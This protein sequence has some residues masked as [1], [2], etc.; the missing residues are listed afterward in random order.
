MNEW[1]SINDF[2]G[3]FSNIDMLHCDTRDFH[4]IF[5]PFGEYEEDTKH[6]I[7]KLRSKGPKKF[8]EQFIIPQDRITEYLKYLLDNTGG[9]ADWRYLFDNKDKHQIWIKYIR[10]YR[11]ND[12]E[13]VCTQG[14]DFDGL[15]WRHLKDN[16]PTLEDLNVCY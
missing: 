1:I 10:F 15:D 4:V 12:T 3:D 16:L 7:D 9:E 14:S 13:F 2:S 11:L 5:H 6:K 8:K